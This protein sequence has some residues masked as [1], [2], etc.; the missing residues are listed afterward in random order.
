MIASLSL[1]SK[2]SF[3]SNPILDVFFKAQNIDTKYRLMVAAKDGVSV[4]EMAS[5]PFTP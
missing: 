1:R 2:I 3:S 5:T 4:L